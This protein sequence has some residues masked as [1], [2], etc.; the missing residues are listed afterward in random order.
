EGERDDDAEPRADREPAEGLLQR[1]P[2]RVSEHAPVVVQG[3]CDLPRRRQQELAEP[4]CERE[5]P[6]QHPGGE[7]DDH[8]RPVLQATRHSS[9][10]AISC[11]VACSAPP[12]TSASR[13][14]VTSS[15]NRGSSRTSFVRGCGRATSIICAI[16]PG[17][18]DITTTRVERNT[19]SGIECVT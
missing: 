19:A 2:A 14:S 13:T 4:R 12:F 10:S 8:G 16:R 15:K 17:R 18:A 6:E 5:L 11:A 9:P 7:D 3:L 1:E